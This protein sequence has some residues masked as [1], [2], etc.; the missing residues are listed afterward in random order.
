MLSQKPTAANSKFGTGN[1]FSVTASGNVEATPGAADVK[2]ASGWMG[3]APAYSVYGKGKRYETGKGLAG[4]TP[5]RMITPGPGQYERES[6]LGNQTLSRKNTSPNV[7]LGTAE[8]AAFSKQYVS[9]AHERSLVGQHSPGAGA[10]S[11]PSS[12]GNQTHSKKRTSQNTKFGSG[13]RFSQIKPVNEERLKSRHTPGPGSY[14][15]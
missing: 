8:R 5:T 2:P 6:S 11:A 7:K 3:D 9:P 14:V 1:R 4:W 12:L 10:Y 13:G 15:V